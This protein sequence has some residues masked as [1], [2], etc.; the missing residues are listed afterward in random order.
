MGSRT[1][2]VLPSGL[3]IEKDDLGVLLAL[4]FCACAHTVLLLGGQVRVDIDDLSVTSVTEEQTSLA[5]GINL[6]V[7]RIV[8][9]DLLSLP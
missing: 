4:N 8:I 3:V 6:E 2:S 5:V 7:R 1:F 9:N